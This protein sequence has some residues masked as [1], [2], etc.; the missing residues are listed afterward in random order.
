[1]EYDINPEIFYNWVKRL[2][3]NPDIISYEYPSDMDP[4]PMERTSI[5]V[6]IPMKV[7]IGSFLL[8]IPNGTD[9]R[10]FWNAL[11]KNSSVMNSDL[12]L[13]KVRV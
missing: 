11:E 13:P 9:P 5:S 3:H 4:A 8:T 7:S 1:M 10:P 6:V 12:H 2:R